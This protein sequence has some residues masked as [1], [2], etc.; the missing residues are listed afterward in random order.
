MSSRFRAS[1]LVLG[2]GALALAACDREEHHS[3]AKPIGE[4]VPAG[5]SPSTIF[6]GSSS[7]PPLD[8]RAELYDTNANAIS[9]GQQLYNWMNCVGCH[10]H[11]GGGMGPALMDDQWRYGSR[12]DQVAATIA[13]GRPN[14][15]PAWRGK[16]TEAQIW[17]LAAY[18]SSLSGL[19]S[20]DAVSSRAESMSAGTPQTLTPHPDTTNSDAAKQ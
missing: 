2:A 8:P 9:R 20:K 17:D 1:L 19:P 4:T 3:R 12:I 10:S 18:V 13:E 14:G 16:L 11:G 7:Q 15:M 5:M 6:P